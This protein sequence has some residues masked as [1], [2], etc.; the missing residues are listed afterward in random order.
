MNDTMRVI[1]PTCASSTRNSLATTTPSSAAPAIHGTRHCRRFA[2][3]IVASARDDQSSES[4]ACTIVERQSA[5]RRVRARRTRNGSSASAIALIHRN[6]SAQSVT[7]T[8][9]ARHGVEDSRVEAPGAHGPDRQ[10]EQDGRLRE[11]QRIEKRHVG[12]R[13]RIAAAMDV[14]GDRPHHEQRDHGN[15]S[16][17]EVAAPMHADGPPRAERELAHDADAERRHEAPWHGAPYAMT[18]LDLAARPRHLVR[19]EEQHEPEE[20][21]MQQVQRNHGRGR[22]SAGHAL[23]VEPPKETGNDRDGNDPCHE[24]AMRK[25]MIERE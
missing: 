10:R 1:V 6:A 7:T 4:T 20:S 5:M 25:Q 21:R 11:V 19:N 13:C 9:L 22:R 18:L 23:P 24:A 12:Q 2:Y 14:G 3:A 16:Q 15:R 17:H 8:A